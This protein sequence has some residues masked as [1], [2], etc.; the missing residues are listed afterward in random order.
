[1]I[2]S[3]SPD[4]WFGT[5]LSWY[6]W[7]MYSTALR[8]DVEFRTEFSPDVWFFLGIIGKCTTTTLCGL[9]SDVEFRTEHAD[10]F[11]WAYHTHKPVLTQLQIHLHSM[12]E[13]HLTAI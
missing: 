2:I 13:I 12:D 6:K 10:T 7:Q 5:E 8:A 11:D 4:V 9:S 1:M 3:V